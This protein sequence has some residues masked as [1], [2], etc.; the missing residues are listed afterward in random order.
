M[1][2]VY[3]KR[4]LDRDLDIVQILNKIKEIEKI[5]Y[6][7]FNQDQLTLFNYFPKPLLCLDEKYKINFKNSFLKKYLKK[8]N[9]KNLKNKEKQRHFG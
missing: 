8:N 7:L 6:T 9:N 3:S 5:K 2:I 1:M 4:M